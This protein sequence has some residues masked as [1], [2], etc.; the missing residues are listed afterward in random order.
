MPM[1]ILRIVYT[2]PFAGDLQNSKE[3]YYG[4]TISANYPPTAIRL[5][6]FPE[7][8]RHLS[9]FQVYLQFVQS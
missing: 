6:H 9:S 3:N 2:F 4:G 7:V 8:K 1:D 5:L